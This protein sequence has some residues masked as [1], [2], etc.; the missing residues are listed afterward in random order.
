[1]SHVPERS[2]V[3]CRVKRPKGDLMRLG[4]DPEGGVSFDVSGQGLGRGAYLC[5]GTAVECLAL[6]GRHH[7]LARSLR[8]GHGVINYAK[9]QSQ[10]AQIEETPP[11]P[12]R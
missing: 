12:P 10:L 6:A 8:L 2:C 4:V 3:G 1:M 7:G 11:S 9:L 5:A